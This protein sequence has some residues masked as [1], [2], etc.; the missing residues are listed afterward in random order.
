M[1][2]TKE[3]VFEQ[4]QLYFPWKELI[5]PISQQ[6]FYFHEEQLISV[7]FLPKGMGRET[8]TET[9]TEAKG[10]EKRPPSVK[11]CQAM[12]RG[13]T[14]TA[15]QTLR[16]KNIRNSLPRQEQHKANNDHSHR[17]SVAPPPFQNYAN[18][19]GGGGGG[20][21]AF[22]FPVEQKIE[23]SPPPPPA[24]GEGEAKRQLRKPKTA[25]PRRGTKEEGSIVLP[26]SRSG[27]QL[28]VLAM[29]EGEAREARKVAH[30]SLIL[31]KG[32]GGEEQK[33][34]SPLSEGRLTPKGRPPAPRKK[35]PQM[36][37]RDGFALNPEFISLPSCH[38]SSP[39]QQGI[40][41]TTLQQQQ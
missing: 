14:K 5:D 24:E 9:E 26:L 19:N 25:P 4:P 30:G 7:W 39:H 28:P 16:I 27:Q 8:E 37:G 2:K 17:G 12:I 11:F 3:T 20:P 33:T 10:N 15:T 13:K 29:K 38:S 31:D 32:K 1:A 6:R 34:M 23:D 36:K 18:S 21:S 22:P 35:P 40:E 41:R